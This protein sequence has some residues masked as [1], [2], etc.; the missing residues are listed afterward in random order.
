MADV[1]LPLTICW[2]PLSY[3]SVTGTPSLASLSLNRP[4]T[5]EQP[6]VASTTASSSRITGRRKERGVWR[7]VIGGLSKA[8]GARTPDNSSARQE[9]SMTDSDAEP[10]RQDRDSRHAVVPGS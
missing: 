4:F 7:G 1:Q 5:V 6:G 8:P 10:A 2:W 9:P 3:S